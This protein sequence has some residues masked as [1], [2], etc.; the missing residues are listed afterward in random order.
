MAKLEEITAVFVRERVRFANADGDVVVGDL[1]LVNGHGET[2]TDGLPISVKVR[3]EVDE[4]QQRGTYRWYGQWTL[5][6]NKRNGQQEHQF[7][8][9]TFVRAAPHGR[10]GVIAY[11]KA[12]GKGNGIGQARA[13]SLWEKFGSDAVRILRDEPEVAAAAVTGLSEDQA[14][15]CSEQLKEDQALEGCTIDLIDLLDGRGFPKD[16]ARR[17]VREW[18]N[19]AADVIKRDPYSLM[20]FR[21]CGF[22]RTDQLWMDLGNPPARL[23]RQA[24]CAW[25][26]VAAD[27][28]GH[29]WYPVEF[30][31][32]GLAGQVPQA[33]I[34]PVAAI[35]LAKRIGR[36]SLDRNGALATMRTDAAS[37]SI[38]DA[39]GRLWV[40]EGR[41]AWCED[42]LAELVVNSLS[43]MPRWPDVAGVRG[44]DG[45]QR[46][47]L[48]R[49]LG[50]MIGILGGS[51]GT[52][53]TYTAA[54]LIGDLS[55]VFGASEIAVAAP[56]GKAAVRIT[57][58]LQGYG[59]QMRART[60]HSLL[61]VGS[62]DELSG[63][64]GFKHNEGNPF[65]YRVLIGDESSMLDTSL[66]SSILRARA[67]G[68]HVLLVGDVNQLPPVGH[69]APLRDLIAA[70]LPYGELTEIKRNSGGIVEACAAIRDAK[71]WTAGDNLVIDEIHG[72]EN[73]LNDLRSVLTQAK[74][75]GFNPVWDC[76]VVVAVNAKSKL[77]R[78][79][80]N[81]MLQAELNT[82]PPVAG[83][84]FRLGD[85]IVNLK[86]G[87][88]PAFDEAG[89]DEEIQQNE[90]GELY[91]ANGEL[92]EVID[93]G[94]KMLVAKLSNPARTIKVP[95]GRAQNQDSQDEGDGGDSDK[96]STGCS[97]DLGYC[98]SVHKA[99]GS[100]FP[101]VVVLIDDYPGARMVCSREWLYTA[102]SRAKKRCVLIGKKQTADRFCRT[103][104]I[105]RRKTF[106]RELIGLKR[107][108]RTL[109]EL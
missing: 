92:A 73:Q 48:A 59:L 98:L 54:A 105:G 7:D 30:A 12:A 102:V 26:T 109:V 1:Q 61:G 47:H 70:G 68:T 37:G 80:V 87:F 45:H 79:D 85:K 35:K 39:G 104:A 46:E 83:T 43:E 18:G 81:K 106:L 14:K 20:S 40:S 42:K 63:N 101:V 62:V 84:P 76:Q 90:R 82:N 21:G 55:A 9:R 41:K 10:A 51:P 64:W 44:I 11:L 34:R 93:V 3:A 38:I 77:S 15:A 74:A 94:E 100:E 53:K 6:K 2:F 25:Y 36:L 72:E 60:W 56:T 50:G 95:R 17:A 22:K 99:Q 49:A 75:D 24:L 78:K 103:R 4:L 108:E 52:G 29:T 5:Y 33:D 89:A 91:V 86:N 19:R 27:T 8:A 88:F 66:L 58:A 31:V 13:T 23:R 65:P 16:T 32:Q 96:S 67:V 28:A 71:P 57:E 107:A 69:G 97:W